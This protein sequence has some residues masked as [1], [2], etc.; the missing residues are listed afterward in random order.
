M[1][2][3][4]RQYPMVNNVKGAATAIYT[5]KFEDTSRESEDD[6]T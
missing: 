3:F 5:Q 6:S 2:I 4:Q 1:L